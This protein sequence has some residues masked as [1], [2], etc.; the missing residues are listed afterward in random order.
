VEPRLPSHSRSFE[1]RPPPTREAVEAALR[2][3][4]ASRSEVRLAYLFGSVA[5]GGAGPLSDVDVAVLVDR[6]ALADRSGFGYEATLVADL[7]DALRFPKVEAAV[8][9]RAP[10]HL[11]F[12]VVRDG[13]LLFEREPGEAIRFRV[14]ALRD[15]F[16]FEPMRRVQN[17]YLREWLGLPPEPDRP[18]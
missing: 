5:S 13:V 14:E 6:E 3:F 16:D 15:H 8:L 18:R 1:N 11:R 4:F 12:N 17:R 10:A 9:N 7:M 2:P